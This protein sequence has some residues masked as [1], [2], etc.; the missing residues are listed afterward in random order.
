MVM[1]KDEQWK[2]EKGFEEVLLARELAWKA[3]ESS[4]I[5]R[6]TAI[7]IEVG[8]VPNDL[9]VVLA[10]MVVGEYLT[11]QRLKEIEAAKESEGG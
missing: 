5:A 3:F 9:G 11:R 10:H 6:A 7:A 4:G 1:L 2:S 8:V